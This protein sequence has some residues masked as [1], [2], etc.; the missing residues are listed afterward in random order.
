MGGAFLAMASVKEDRQGV[1]REVVMLFREV[2]LCSFFYGV[3][4]TR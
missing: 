2:M 3:E 1:E 4:S